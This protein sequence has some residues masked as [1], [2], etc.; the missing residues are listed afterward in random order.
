MERMRTRDRILFL[1]QISNV[2]LEPPHLPHAA[3]QLPGKKSLYCRMI[4]QGIIS[5]VLYILQM[6]EI[7]HQ[8]WG[9]VCWYFEDSWEQFRLLGLVDVI[10]NDE[11]DPRKM[12]VRRY[13]ILG[14]QHLTG[15]KW[16]G[17]MARINSGLE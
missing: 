13:A 8:P 15:S 2:T 16:R 11:E 4:P 14:L 12:E 9:E 6:G 7:A 17:S 1:L 3:Q 10:G 5:V